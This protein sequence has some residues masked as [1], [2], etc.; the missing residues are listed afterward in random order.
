MLLKLLVKDK[1][2]YSRKVLVSARMANE[3]SKERETRPPRRRETRLQQMRD[4]LAA[5][6]PEERKRT[7]QQ[8]TNQFERL[9]VETPRREN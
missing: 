6:N 8:S 2:L 9:P 1:P 7:L 4:R 3:T 5:E